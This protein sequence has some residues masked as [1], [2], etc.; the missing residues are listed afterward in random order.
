[1]RILNISKSNLVKILYSIFDTIIY[2]VAT[3]Y[4]LQISQEENSY[5]IWRKDV[6]RRR[7]FSALIESFCIIPKSL[8]NFADQTWSFS[9]FNLLIFIVMAYDINKSDFLKNIINIL[10]SCIPF[11]PSVF[12]IESLWEPGFD[13]FLIYYKISCYWSSPP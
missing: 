12:I 5:I 11:R 6:S 13:P 1:M 3:Q 2:N 8:L 7:F 9:L 4:Q 10:Y